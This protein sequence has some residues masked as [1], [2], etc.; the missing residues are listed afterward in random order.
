MRAT[1]IPNRTEY[2]PLFTTSQSNDSPIV[3]NEPD[4]NPRL[5]RKAYVEIARPRTARSITRCRTCLSFPSILFGRRGRRLAPGLER[6]RLERLL[7]GEPRRIREHPGRISLDP[8][9]LALL[10]HGLGAARRAFHVVHLREGRPEQRL[11]L[12]AMRAPPG[13]VH[14]VPLF[15]EA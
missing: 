8:V 2:G 7:A 5:C 6:E 14:D 12:G 3:Q 10:R 11:L 4:E 9:V 15:G 1:G 13:A